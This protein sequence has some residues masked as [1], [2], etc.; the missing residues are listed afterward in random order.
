MIYVAAQATGV[1]NALC[2]LELHND[3]SHGSERWC[4]YV[5]NKWGAVIVMDMWMYGDEVAYVCT[6][7]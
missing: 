4:V 7:R 2:R 5:L 1:Y 3:Y 6:C